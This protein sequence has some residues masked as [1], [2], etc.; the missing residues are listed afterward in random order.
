MRTT[1]PRLLRSIVP[2]RISTR[3]LVQRSTRYATS[4]VYD[5][6]YL[7]I[8]KL[9]LERSNRCRVWCRYLCRDIITIREAAWL[10][11]NTYKYEDV[12]RMMGEISAVLL[13][14]FRVRVCDNF[15]FSFVMVGAFCFLRC[16]LGWMTGR[17][18]R[19]NKHVP[20]IFRGSAEDQLD[21]ED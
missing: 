12:V 4:N 1:S 10:T 6:D 11:D 7:V 18:S 19:L 14:N 8:S 20:L 3:D 2:N 15:D 9:L 13:G 5:Y 17:A 21:H 16:S